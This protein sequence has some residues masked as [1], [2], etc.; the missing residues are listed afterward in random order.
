M[1]VGQE[2]RRRREDKGW[3]QAKLGVLSGTGPSG[4]SQIETGRRNPSTATLQRIA[5]AL[6]VEVRELFPLE[7]TPLP[8]F[9][10]GRGFDAWI[11]TLEQYK[12]LRE[13]ISGF[14][15]LGPGKRRMVLEESLELLQNLRKV[16]NPADLDLALLHDAIHQAVL[17]M[18][19]ISELE[20]ERGSAGADIVDIEKYKAQ[21]AEV[22]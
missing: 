10:A 1:T 18:I 17:R 6:G 9:E 3:S 2:I 21:V 15:E 14:E 4:I 22:A 20:Q 16:Y 13:E 12:S 7:Q 8:D 19:A 5:G 11:V